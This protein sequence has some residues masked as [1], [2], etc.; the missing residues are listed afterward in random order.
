M[1]KNSMNSLRSV[2]LLLGL[3]LM[4]MLSI[5]LTVLGWYSTRGVVAASVETQL[6]AASGLGVVDIEGWLEKHIARV[7]EMAT[8]AQVTRLMPH[9]VNAFLSDRLAR[10]DEYSSFWLSDLQGNWYSPLGTSGSIAQR[11]YFPEVIRTKKTVISSPLIGQADGAL[12][13]VLAVPVFVGGEMAAILGANL[14]VSALV[15]EVNA[16]KVGQNGYVALYESSGLT[17]IDKDAAKTLKYNPFDDPEHSFSKIK[18]ALLSAQG[19][20]LPA[21]IDGEQFY[22][23]SQKLDLTDW[24]MVSCAKKDEFIAPL[25]DAV[26]V[27]IIGTVVIVVIAFIVL[28]YFASRIVRPLG[29]F[30][31]VISGMSVGNMTIESGITSHGAIADIARSLDEVRERLRSMIVS[32]RTSVD[33]VTSDTKRIY[34]EVGSISDLAKQT[35]SGSREIMDNCRRDAQT[36]E[37]ISS[38]VSQISTSISKVDDGMRSIADSADDSVKLADKGNKEVLSVIEQMHKIK[39]AVEHASGVITELGESS[40][41]ISEIVD[42]IANISKQTNLLAVNASIEAARAGEQGRGFAVVAGEVGKLASETSDATERISKL[43]EDMQEHA[44]KAI[45]SIESGMHEVSVGTDVVQSAGKVFS[46]IQAII[47]SLLAQLSDIKND[48][49]A[50]ASERQGLILAATGIETS[51]RETSSRSENAVGAMDDQQERIND[52]KRDITA[53]TEMADR[54]KQDISAFR[55]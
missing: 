26:K 4:L 53:L 10:Y 15:N 25:Y 13:V 27:N 36:A 3:T 7:E 19:G 28:L 42:S 17:V 37:A 2:M 1:N 14:K 30:N 8:S 44:G 11:A 31:S 51:V 23:H 48:V 21:V 16:I 18:G 45:E 22:V 43:A 54:L 33:S 6:R 49:E 29:G 50:I 35:S 9:E 20:M 46:D 55:T 34:D 40:R 12:T 32:V 24:V 38:A 52:M 5:V 41:H 39:Q 47:N